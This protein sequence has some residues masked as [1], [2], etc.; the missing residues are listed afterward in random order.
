MKGTKPKT[1][2]STKTSAAPTTKA[3]AATSSSSG[4]RNPSTASKHITILVMAFGN[5][6]V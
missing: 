4:Q 2:T 6:F 1:T 3:A 5:R